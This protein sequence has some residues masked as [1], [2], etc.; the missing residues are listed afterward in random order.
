MI[1]PVHT[2]FVTA[3]PLGRQGES[4]A[5]FFKLQ[6][7]NAMKKPREIHTYEMFCEQMASPEFVAILTIGLQMLAKKVEEEGL[8]WMTGD[9]ERMAV[10]FVRWNDEQKR[11]AIQAM[12]DCMKDGEYDGPETAAELCGILDL[13][14]Q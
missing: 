4:P 1:F 12:A 7:K 2:G 9:D 5:S 3:A 10:Y 11:I 6:K 13:S 8:S 14:I